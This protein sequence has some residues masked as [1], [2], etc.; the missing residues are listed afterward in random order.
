MLP[1]VCRLLLCAALSR[2]TVAGATG[3]NASLAP[4]GDG[5][6]EAKLIGVYK[7]VGAGKTR[8]ALV[9]AE[10]LVRQ[11]PTFQLAQLV[12]GDLLA[13]RTRPVNSF[14]DVREVSQAANQNLQ[15]LRSEA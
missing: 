1:T 7:L 5:I 10:A 14:G 12:H 11:F 15:E 3:A 9:Q 13:A 4:G 6:A 2:H 8:Q